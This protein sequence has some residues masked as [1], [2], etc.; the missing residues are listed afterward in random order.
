M[1]RYDYNPDGKSEVARLM[2]RIERSCEAIERVMNDPG[3]R[4]SHEAIRLRYAAL[5]QEQEQLAQF[6][7]EEASIDAM[8]DIYDDVLNRP[9][10]R[11]KKR[12]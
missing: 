12:S 5:G 6:I 3:Y 8:C 9:A 11:S 2:Y 10:A 4:A 1:S 7:G